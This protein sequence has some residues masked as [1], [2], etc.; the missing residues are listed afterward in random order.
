MGDVSEASLLDYIYSSGGK[1]TNSDLMKTYKQF[2]S[3]SDLQLR[4]EQ[5]KVLAVFVF[6]PSLALHVDDDAG[7]VTASS[8]SQPDTSATA[9]LFRLFNQAYSVL[10]FK[11]ILVNPLRTFRKLKNAVGPM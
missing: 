5:S 1:V 10:L 7:N 2:V 8:S 4:G 11:L 6:A 9:Y 3:H